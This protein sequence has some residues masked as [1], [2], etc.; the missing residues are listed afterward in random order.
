VV[1]I[2][3]DSLPGVNMTGVVESISG[4]PDVQGGDVLY[5]VHIRMDKIDPLLRWGMTME[6]TFTG[7]K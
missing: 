6:V 7:K 4:A 3:A 2:S 5:K 1:G